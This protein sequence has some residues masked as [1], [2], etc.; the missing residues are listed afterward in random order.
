MVD[1]VADFDY[2]N[3]TFKIAKRMVFGFALE[4]AMTIIASVKI[5]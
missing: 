2:V 5:R 3:D 4:R 1:D